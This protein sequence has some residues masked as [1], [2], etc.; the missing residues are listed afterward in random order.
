MI[1]N[2]SNISPNIVPGNWWISSVSR[3]CSRR[4]RPNIVFILADDYGWNDSEFMGSDLYETDNIDKLA[5]KSMI[6]TQGYSAS[7]VSSPSRASIMTGL[8]TPRH[9]I[10]N[11]IGE[12][13][14]TAWRGKSRF[15][16]LLPADYKH[17]LD[18]NFT[19]IAEILKSDG[20]VTFM[21]G[22]WHL[23][24]INTPGKHGFD[25]SIGYVQ[26]GEKGGYFHPYHLNGLENGRTGE[27]IDERLGKET[28]EFIESQVKQGKPFFAYLSFYAVHAQIQCTEKL[29]NK[30]REKIEKH[31]LGN[32]YEGFDIDRT[33]PV[34]KYQD[35]PVYAGLIEHMDNGVGTVLDKIRELGIEDNTIIIF[36]S[37]NGGVSSGDNYST[38]NSPL[39]GGKGRQ[40]EDA[41]RVPLVIHIPGMTSSRICNTPVC[42]IDFFPT[43]AE[44]TGID[45][46]EGKLDGIS[47]VPL[48]EGKKIDERSLFWHY[49]HYGNQG[50]EPSSIIREGDWKLIHYYETGKNELYNLSEDISETVDLAPANQEKVR[51]LRK[52]LDKWLVETGASMPEKDPEYS[53]G[54]DLDYREKT[55]AQLIKKLEKSRKEMLDIRWC[56]DRTWWGS[57]RTAD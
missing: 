46:L 37:D 56:P 21:A 30:Y 7:S 44:L 41:I 31:G 33:Q 49:P 52:K 54:K 38:S 20:Y 50:G 18:E 17:E 35:N 22:K 39:R 48:L 12:P 19:T 8:Y 47:L 3:N 34:R 36:T 15:S 4:K 27:E 43:I 45:E 57:H 55:N 26:T 51:S 1:I 24:T 9:G 16:K 32:D 14:G 53:V 10:T 28:A 40:W 5:S 11:W 6:Y 13:S 25:V 2:E 29:W 42:G 23:G